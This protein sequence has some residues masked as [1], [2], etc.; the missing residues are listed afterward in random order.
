MNSI[1]MHTGMLKLKEQVRELVLEE[2]YAIQWHHILSRHPNITED[3]IINGLL[4]GYY[5]PDR[6]MEGQYISGSR[7][8]YPPGLI[9]IVFEVHETDAGNLVRIITAFDED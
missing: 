2:K 5:K 6:E 7:M 1:D 4:Y 9:R 3:D 8:N